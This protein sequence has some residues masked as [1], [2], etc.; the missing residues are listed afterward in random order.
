MYNVYTYVMHKYIHKL[1]LELD[2]MNTC[3]LHLKYSLECNN[4]CTLRSDNSNHN[5]IS[6]SEGK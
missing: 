5:F 4:L 6:Q 2:Y 1:F 3:T